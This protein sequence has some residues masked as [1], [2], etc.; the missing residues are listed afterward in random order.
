V[1]Y[2]LAALQGI[3]PPALDAI[4]DPVKLAVGRVRGPEP[5]QWTH[6]GR[7]AFIAW[8]HAAG[9]DFAEVMTAGELRGLLA[10]EG[11]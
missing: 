1:L 4:G 8:P 2:D 5:E 11:G 6:A 9:A 3:R 7:G 10:Q